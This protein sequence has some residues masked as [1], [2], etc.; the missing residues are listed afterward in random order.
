M[1]PAGSKSVRLRV[2]TVK[3]W[4]RAV[5][6]I[7]LYRSTRIQSGRRIPFRAGEQPIDD[8]LIGPSRAPDEAVLA[9]VETF[10]LEFLPGLNAI[11]LSELSRQ[12]D[13]PLGGYL[14]LHH[15]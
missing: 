7:K 10:D 2:A 8:T 12:D 5:A 13:L 15:M 14:R 9:M 6:P 4:T 11:L 3:P 1:T